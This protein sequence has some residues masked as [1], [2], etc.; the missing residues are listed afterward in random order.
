[1]AGSSCPFTIAIRTQET[2]FSISL[3][4]SRR[5]IR[6]WQ[7]AV[8]R[9]T[10]SPQTIGEDQPRP[11][12]ST[13]HSTF[14]VADHLSGSPGCSATPREFSPRKDGQLGE[15]A[16][17]PVASDTNKPKMRNPIFFGITFLPANNGI[18]NRNIAV[19]EQQGNVE[20]PRK[21]TEYRSAA[22]AGPGDFSEGMD[23]QANSSRQ[24]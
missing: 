5:T 17:N 22:S 12:T 16:S 8:V 7:V 6:F 15:F 24:T 18:E 21:V 23:S 4:P 2:D 13:F 19:T 11:F 20:T 14:S 9:N 3:L 1:L 10:L